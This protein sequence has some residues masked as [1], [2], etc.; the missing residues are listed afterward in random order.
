MWENE[1][2]IDIAAPPDKVYHYLSDFARH[3]EWSMS[4]ATIEQVT[5]G[6]VSV[7]TEFKSSETIPQKFV[8]VARVTAL[9]VPS[10]ISWESTDYR[11]FRTQWSLSMS[12]RNGGTHLTQH[13]RFE[14]IG[15]LGNLLLLMR[16]LQVPPENRKSLARIKEKLES[17]EPPAVQ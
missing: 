16:R 7:G 4:V 2:G 9:Q 15:L 3:S 10:L 13:V 6:P 1:V 5:P 12:E 14:P 17:K 11:I 8:S